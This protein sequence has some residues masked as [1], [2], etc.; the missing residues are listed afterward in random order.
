SLPAE[1]LL[2]GE[3]PGAEEIKRGVPFV[4]QAGVNLDGF[5]QLAGLTRDKVL[6]TNTVKCRPTKNQ[7][8]ANRRPTACEIKSC[9][10]WLDA[11]LRL[12]SPPVLITLGDVALKRLGGPALRLAECHGRPLTLN[13][14]AVI[15]MYH[16]AAIIYRRQLEPVLAADFTALGQI[17]AGLPDRQNGYSDPVLVSTHSPG[18]Q[19]Y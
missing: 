11:E 8:R 15:P 12:L 16:P 7:G 6:I 2:L 19:N 3:A 9:A 14:A 5:L 1:I 10:R 17:L 13:G 18:K 4:G